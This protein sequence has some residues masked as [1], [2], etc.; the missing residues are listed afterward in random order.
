MSEIY[1]PVLD[2]LVPSESE[3]EYPYR[4]QQ[5]GEVHVLHVSAGQ[6][7]RDDLD[8]LIIRVKAESIRGITKW[9]RSKG[10][11]I[12]PETEGGI[13][14]V[15][16]QLCQVRYRKNFRALGEHIC[17]NLKDVDENTTEQAALQKFYGLLVE[18]QTFME[19]Y[20]DGLSRETQ[21]GLYGELNV[22]RDVVLTSASEDI[23]AVKGWLGWERK[24]QDFQFPEMAIE[25]KTTSQN[26]PEKIH[27]S[28]VLQ[29]DDHGL[30]PLLLAVVHV[31]RNHAKGE[32]LPE[33]V[34]ALRKRLGS[35]SE[36]CKLLNRGLMEAG[37]IDEHEEQYLSARYKLLKRDFYRVR[38]KFPR[39]ITKQ[40]LPGVTDVKYDIN[41]QACQGF[42][43][44]EEVAV[45]A[46]KEAAL[47]ET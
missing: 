23:W 22:L 11:E 46:I 36:P 43:V 2:S 5:I 14:R 30:D 38:D 25:V 42:K 41:I 21:T 31:D 6:R 8:N 13:T 15:V 34:Q 10:F 28:N 37:Y 26:I 17:Q 7:V 9:P 27:I 33:M 20:P 18:W 47:K 19:K 40:L 1:G 3:K 24:N 32:T 35:G 12:I 45:S 44:N 29:L 4:N 39:L 16:L